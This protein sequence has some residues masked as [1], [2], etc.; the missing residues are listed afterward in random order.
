[1]WFQQLFSRK[2]FFLGISASAL[3]ICALI[4][5]ILLSF[6]EKPA[7]ELPVEEV[8][9]PEPPAPPSQAEILM[10]ALSRAYPD[11]IGQAEFRDDDWAFEIGGKWFYYA[12]GRIIPEDLRDK[13]QE[14][15]QT[16][17]YNTYPVGMPWNPPVMERPLRTQTAA[18]RDNSQGSRPIGRRPQFFY[19][20]LWSITSREEAYSQMRRVNFLGHPVTVHNGI[21]KELNFVEGKILAAAEDNPVVRKWIDSLDLVDAWSWRNVASSVNRSFHSYGIA[22]DILP[23]NLGGLETYWQWTARHTPEWWTVPVSR[24]YHPPDE[25]ILAFESAGFIWG[26]KWAY[27]DTMHFEYHPEVFVLSGSPLR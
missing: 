8:S 17:F 5:F 12:E 19:E 20:A 21:V 1:M 26:G 6:Q 14:Y 18:G 15:S 13:A 2:F 24:R 23:K 3:L 27:Y 16:R 22:I 7:P 4:V 25:V 9:E 11:R 10:T